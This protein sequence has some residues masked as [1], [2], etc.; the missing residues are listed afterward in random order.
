M[1]EISYTEEQVIK[2]L[3]KFANDV[4]DSYRC[5]TT[6]N[7][8]ASEILDLIIK[9]GV[10][11]YFTQITEEKLAKK[12]KEL[13]KG[14]FTNPHDGNKDKFRELQITNFE[15]KKIGDKLVIDI[16]LPN[17]NVFIGKSFDGAKDYLIHF[18]EI[19]VEFNVIE[20]DIFK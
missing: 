20:H 3:N 8:K 17:K 1:K 9:N 18:L 7:Y 4:D 14:Y 15:L 5:M 13:F 2:M 12:A 19:P 10:E 16:T 11:N 6:D